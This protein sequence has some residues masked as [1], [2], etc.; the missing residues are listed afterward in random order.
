[1]IKI[2]DLFLFLLGIVLTMIGLF[3]LIIYLN[4]LT[5]GYSFFDFVKFIIMRV[6][7]LSFFV[8][9]I[10]IVLKVERWRKVEFLL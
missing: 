8:G 2:K 9:L 1:M 5:M 10:L 6:E 3:Y 7:C 4:V